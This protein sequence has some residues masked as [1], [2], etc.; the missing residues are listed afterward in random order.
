MSGYDDI[1]R[2][3]LI[4]LRDEGL[5]RKE[6]AKRLGVSYGGLAG[7]L[8]YL[9][10]EW[11]NAKWTL[12]VSV[13]MKNRMADI[14]SRHEAG[15]THT[16]IA[17][18]YGI[19][20]ERVR[21]IVKKAGGTPRHV[22]NDERFVSIVDAVASAPPGLSMRELVSE[23]GLDPDTIRQAASA[24]GV[25]IPRRHS[26]TTAMLREMSEKVKAGESFNAAS[27]GDHSLAAL[28]QR[29]C[30]ENGIKSMAPCRWTVDPEMRRRVIAEMRAK[31]ETWKEIA[32]VIAENEGVRSIGHVTVYAWVTRHAPELLQ[33]KP[34]KPAKP[35]RRAYR[36]AHKA[37]AVKR[38]APIEVEIKEDVRETAIAN[39]GKAPASAIAKAVGVS[40]NSII[41]YWF[42]AR[43]T[44]E[45]A[46]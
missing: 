39:Y 42:R 8:H 7:K 31:G 15:E 28:L 35:E 1:I 2:D 12:A 19:T 36:R 34:P 32:R 46:A 26:D 11:P 45:I 29:F 9:G 17:A 5:T 16:D 14:L 38:F 23:T 18:D 44:G 43:Q 33:I 6:A 10:L 13:E 40:R 3:A 22:Q 25:K 21:Q 20:R 27:G 41:G 4:S 37:V 30:E 24:A